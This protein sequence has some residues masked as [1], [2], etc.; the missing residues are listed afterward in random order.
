MAALLLAGVLA[1]IL[2]F[3][4][5]RA[6]I[7][8]V[9]AVAEVVT[10][11]TGYILL[12]I[13]KSVLWVSAITIPVFLL[14]PSAGAGL[15]GWPLTGAAVLGGFVFGVGAAINGA[16]AFSTLARLADGEGRMLVTGAAFGLGVLCFVLLI[17]WRLIERP[18]PTPALIGSLLG[19]PL[20]VVAAALA[21]WAVYEMARLWRTRPAGRCVH[22]LVLAP[23]YR[24]SS[25]AMLIGI[26]GA[27]IF[28]IY[29]SIGYTMTLQQLVEGLHG[30]RSFPAAASWLLFLAILAGMLLSTW[31]RRS[32]RPDWRPRLI[33]LRNL[34][35]G[36]LMGAGVAL[37]P[38]GNDAL[39]LYG[40]PSLSP[41]ALP[42]YLAMVV[43]IGLGQWSMRAL[44]GIE[45]QVACRN[46]LYTAAETPAKTRRPA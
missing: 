34:C 17:D 9:R 23:Q 31:Q 44:L 1:A 28:L 14:M 18:A 33:W 45:L 10:S 36:L 29:G 21:V 32:F 20:V 38:G 26:A 43:G 22:A 46:D 16:C 3:A 24:L 25:A 41:H 11:G 15:S 7:C 40:I 6:S 5:H 39:V 4:A 8:N 37:T 2:G 19:W 13:G 42:A 27:T 30:T 35:G 12:G